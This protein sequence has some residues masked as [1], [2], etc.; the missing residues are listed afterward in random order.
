MGWRLAE[1]VLDRLPATV[2][3]GAR[4]YLCVLAQ[5]ANDDT[6]K[7]LPG[8][9]GEGLATIV[10]RRTGLGPGGQR[11]AVRRLAKAGVDPR[12]AER[13]DKNGDPLFA[14][15]GRSL[16][17]RIPT[18]P[19]AA[20]GESTSA[21]LPPEGV[22]VDAPD[23]AEGESTSAAVESTSAAVEST[24]APHTNTEY[25]TTAADSVRDAVAVLLDNHGAEIDELDA[26]D[27]VAAVI[28]V[29]NPDNV[30]AYVATFNAASV[31]R[32]AREERQRQEA[33]EAEARRQQRAQE[34]KCTEC[35]KPRSACERIP[36]LV[37]GHRF[38]LHHGDELTQLTPDGPRERDDAFLATFESVGDTARE[39]AAQ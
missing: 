21:P 3:P 29:R 20:E 15:P 1:E 25:R 5:L 37:S 22:S 8:K 18:F 33:L 19:D 17:F 23:A 11:S 34:P 31:K 32:R 13:W 24:S 28:R 14:V 12:I 2:D 38:R 7:V 39:A 30:A 4:L 26:H 36:A 27:C 10:A 6:R 9:D 35:S 16:S